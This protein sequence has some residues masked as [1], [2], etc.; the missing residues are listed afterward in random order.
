MSETKWMTTIPRGFGLIG[1]VEFEDRVYC[2]GATYDATTDRHEIARRAYKAGQER[3]RFETSPRFWLVRLRMWWS[4]RK[5]RRMQLMRFNPE[6]GAHE[7]VY[8]GIRG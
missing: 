1:S 5:G 4:M 6:T 8:G 2:A 7:R 3:H